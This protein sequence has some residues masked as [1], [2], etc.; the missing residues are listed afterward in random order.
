MGFSKIFLITDFGTKDWYV[1]ALKS[2]ILDINADVKIIDATHDIPSFD[3]ITTSF[4]LHQ[5]ERNINEPSIY[6]V[7]VD[8]GVGGKEHSRIIV[9]N[10]NGN[11]FIGPDNGIFSMI[12]HDNPKVFNIDLEKLQTKLPLLDISNTFHGRD[13]FGPTAALISNG[14]EISEIASTADYFLQENFSEVEQENQTLIG[15]LVYADKFGNVISN[16]DKEIFCKSFTS[17]QNVFCTIE[18][19]KK[20]PFYSTY[21]DVKKGE[22]LAL[23][24]SSGYL[25][26]AVNK[27]SAADLLSFELGEKIT[28]STK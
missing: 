23:F 1:P 5:L 10:F 16:I 14:I 8:P 22:F 20:I 11:I 15:K 12:Y 13:I 17:K 21:S 28:L 24:G 26:V 6:L 2:S 27:G 3:V 7:V 9:E 4:Y 25:E 18:T 19:G